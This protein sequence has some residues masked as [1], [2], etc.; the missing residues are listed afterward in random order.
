MQAHEARVAKDRE[1]MTAQA[2]LDA[3]ALNVQEERRI[4]EREEN[5]R[6][7]EEATAKA[8]QQELEFRSAY[9]NASLVVSQTHGSGKK[10]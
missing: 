6:K 5:Q 4:A 3:N 1:Y 7:A 8:Q 2:K 9:S 10:R